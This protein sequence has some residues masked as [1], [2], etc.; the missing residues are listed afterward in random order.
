MKLASTGVNVETRSFERCA[1]VR[2]D[3]GKQHALMRGEAHVRFERRA[4]LADGRFDLPLGRVV[5]AAVFDVESVEPT[6]VALRD[7]VI[8]GLKV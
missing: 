5:N 2:L 4:D 6:A 3:V 1:T 8:L 7:L